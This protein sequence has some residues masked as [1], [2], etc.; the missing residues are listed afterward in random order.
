MHART[1]TVTG[2]HTANWNNNLQCQYGVCC[3]I[4]M[5]LRSRGFA[6][7]TKFWKYITYQQ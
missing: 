2:L 7:S 3:E 5:A 1:H 6:E 4:W